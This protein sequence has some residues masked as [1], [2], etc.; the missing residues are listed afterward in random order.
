MNLFCTC[1]IQQVLM[2]T[3]LKKYKLLFINKFYYISAITDK[4]GRVTPLH[5]WPHHTI[6]SL[7]IFQH[8][9]LYFT[10]YL[11]FQDSKQNPSLPINCTNGHTPCS[12]THVLYAS[13]RSEGFNWSVLQQK[14]WT[15]AKTKERRLMGPKWLFRRNKGMLYK[16]QSSSNKGRADNGHRRKTS[17]RKRDKSMVKTMLFS[18]KCISRCAQ[19]CS[20]IIVRA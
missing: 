17:E 2:G 10:P 3:N 13:V 7:I 18:Q 14:S 20:L 11:S 16:K 19:H 6:L 5:I 8:A 4:M 12:F 9:P 1:D 15:S